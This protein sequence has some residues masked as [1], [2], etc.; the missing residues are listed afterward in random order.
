VGTVGHGALGRW[1]RPRGSRLKLGSESA[2][3]LWRLQ[4][5]ENQVA[6]YDGR[7]P[8]QQRALKLLEPHLVCARC[9]H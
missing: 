3:G 2:T 8:L 9:V 6:S 4:A 7:T 5:E 1:P